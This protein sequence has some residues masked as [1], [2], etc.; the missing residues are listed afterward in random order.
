MDSTTLTHD[1]TQT[2]REL[3]QPIELCT[4]NGTVETAHCSDIYIEDLDF[5]IAALLLDNSPPLSSLGK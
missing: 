2:V 1:K 4:A 5:T 3:E